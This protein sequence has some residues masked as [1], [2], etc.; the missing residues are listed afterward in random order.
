MIYGY[1]RLAIQQDLGESLEMQ[2]QKLLKINDKIDYIFAEYG[3][4]L[5]ENR[6]QLN[7][8]LETVTDGDTIVVTDIHRLSRDLR[9]IDNI[10]ELAKKK[11]MK[12]QFETTIYDYTEN[13]LEL[14]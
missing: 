5:D 14:K 3:S 7:K 1:A 8:M 12:L 9:Q 13:T 11:N 4:G 10:I 6:T 2:K